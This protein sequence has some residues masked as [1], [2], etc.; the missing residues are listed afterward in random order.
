MSM[1]DCVF[2]MHYYVLLNMTLFDYVVV[3]VVVFI[4]LQY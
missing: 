1:Y 2:I 3:V 4:I